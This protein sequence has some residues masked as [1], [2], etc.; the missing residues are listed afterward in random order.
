MYMYLKLG[1]LGGLDLHVG[2]EVSDSFRSHAA[3]IR[4]TETNHMPAWEK[5]YI[6][7]AQEGFNQHHVQQLCNL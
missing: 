1:E 6:N 3:Q 7:S 4:L 5:P 2:L